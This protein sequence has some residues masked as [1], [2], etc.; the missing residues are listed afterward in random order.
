MNFAVAVV[1][2]GKLGG[3]LAALLAA[4]GNR[5]FG[6][7]LNPSTVEDLNQDKPRSEPCF[8]TTLKVAREWLTLTTEF[9]E[10]I[11]QTSAACVVVPTPSD[12]AHPRFSPDQVLSAVERIVEQVTTASLPRYTI[13]IISTLMPGDCDRVIWP[14][15]KRALLKSSCRIDLVYSPEFIALG[16]VLR[17]LERPDFLLIGGPSAEANEQVVELH[18]SLHSVE[19][20]V[21]QTNWINA[22]LAK[23]AVNC[24]LGVKI[25]WANLLAAVCENFSS[26]DVD[27]V[28][29]AVGHDSRIGP[30]YLTGGLGF[31]GPCL[32]R[33][34]RALVS[35]VGSLEIGTQLAETIV[36]WNDGQPA[37]VVDLISAHLPAGKTVGFLGVTYREDSA[38][39]EASQPLRIA[40]ALARR[41]HKVIVFEP[42]GGSELFTACRE[43]AASGGELAVESGGLHFVATAAECIEQADCVVLAKRCELWKQVPATSWQQRVALVFDCWRQLPPAM[44]ESLSGT[45]L[46]VGRAVPA[47]KPEELR[48]QCS[49]DAMPPEPNENRG[50]STVANPLKGAILAEMG[51]ARRRPVERSQSNVIP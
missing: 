2:L 34:I 20:P 45:Y 48:Q 10:A 1:G 5:V 49:P 39:V 28:T 3:P 13:D 19:V 8:A 21:V 51:T 29:R 15:V 37:R 7:D 11:P 44:V 40:Q 4:R 36:A 9:A 35:L 32:P 6:I 26:A 41:G 17:G 46:A 23:L 22:E 25:S 33:D 16:D 43:L 47:P 30:K 50:K 14:L 27:E 31:G 18:R 12:S 24:L 42:L 38:V